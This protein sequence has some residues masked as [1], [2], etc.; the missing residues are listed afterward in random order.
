MSRYLVTTMYLELPKHLII[1][2]R[3]SRCYALL[4]YTTMLRV[5]NKLFC[6]HRSMQIRL[7]FLV[8]SGHK[9]F[10]GGTPEGLEG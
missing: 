8:K 2:N 10:I 6:S 1:W 9:S 4:C 3:W 7:L 5:I